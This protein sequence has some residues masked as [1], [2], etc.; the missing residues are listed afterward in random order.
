MPP[1]TDALIL[2]PALL[3]DS[4]LYQHVVDALALEV[5]TIVPEVWHANN[6]AELANSLLETLPARFAL[7]GNSMGGYLALE[8]VRQAP[9]RVTHLALIGTNAHAD[10]AAAREKREQAI[11]LA[12]AGKFET[13]FDGYFEAALYDGNRPNC[14]PVLRQMARDLGPEALING[15]TAIMARRSSEDILEAISVPSMVICGREDAFASPEAHQSLAG[16]IP[17]ASCH[18]IE[19]C[20][21]LVPLEAP[22]QLAA[23]L[24]ALL[25]V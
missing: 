17:G 15:Q 12:R 24:D 9:E 23:S 8:M 4:R 14:G 16:A 3:C 20:G 13:F 11:R 5:P 22:Q 21:H 10:P 18:V 2:L 25:A 19:G 1:K 6:L 7:A